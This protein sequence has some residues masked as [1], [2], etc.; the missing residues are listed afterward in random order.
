[1]VRLYLPTKNR[2]L[3][4]E[5]GAGNNLPPKAEKDDHIGYLSRKTQN[6]NGLTPEED[7]GGIILY[8]KASRKFAENPLDALFTVL[9]EAFGDMNLPYMVLSPE[10]EPT[11][12]DVMITIS[13]AHLTEET[14]AKLDAESQWQDSDVADG[15]G[16]V[17]YRKGP[18]AYGWY[19]YLDDI[20]LDVVRN[21]L[22]KVDC[23]ETDRN[24][25]WMRH[26]DLLQAILWANNHGA[27]I[28]CFDSGAKIVGGLP[29][30]VN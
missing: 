13:S 4:F 15:L 14:R 18:Y 3:S 20:D 12:R 25:V 24:S 30:F 11:K 22:A 9:D 5:P 8:D 2:L 19:L 16:M 26:P 27:S 7:N 10:K 1:M 21:D 28:L 6:L 29:S 23:G 17:V